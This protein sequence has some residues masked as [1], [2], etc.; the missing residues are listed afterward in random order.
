MRSVA[1]VMTLEDLRAE[2]AQGRCPDFLA[3]L[4]RAPDVPPEVGDE[5]SPF[6]LAR[7]QD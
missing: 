6:A 7:P 3:V 5:W 4:D 2:A 1:S